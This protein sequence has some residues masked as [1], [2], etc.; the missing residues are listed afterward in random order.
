M[1]KGALQMLTKY[2]QRLERILERLIWEQI[3][4]LLIRNKRLRAFLF[5]SLGFA[6]NILFILYNL[7]VGQFSSS[8]GFY[9]LALYYGILAAMRVLVYCF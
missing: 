6:F 7:L 5:I 4:S 8:L 2:R 3:A 9:D 1:I